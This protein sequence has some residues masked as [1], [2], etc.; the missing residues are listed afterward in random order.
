MKAIGAR[1]S[2]ILMLFLFES[3]ILG[4]LGGIIGILIGAGF[5]KL[6]E[7]IATAYLQSALLKA[8][9]PWPLIVGTLAFSVVVGALSG[10]MPAHRASKMNPVDS[11]RYE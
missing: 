3:G 4:F 7:V 2:N 6:V 8:Y 10:L 11:L 1:N 5:S 9:F